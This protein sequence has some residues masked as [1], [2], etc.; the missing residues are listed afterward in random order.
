MVEGSQ[1]DEVGRNRSLPEYSS[2]SLRDLREAGVV[3]RSKLMTGIK[4]AEGRA[5]AFLVG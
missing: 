5:M 3:R 2:G 1:H 4:S